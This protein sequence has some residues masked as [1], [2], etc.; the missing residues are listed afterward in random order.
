MAGRNA[1]FIDT[2]GHAAFDGMRNSGAAATDVV[3]L[4]LLFFL[5]ST[6]LYD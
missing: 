5:S 1:V 4:V 6:Y 3:I 2:P